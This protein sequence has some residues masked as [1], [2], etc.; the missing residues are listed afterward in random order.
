MHGAD[1]YRVCNKFG[2]KDLVNLVCFGDV[3]VNGVDKLG[4]IVNEKTWRK[5]ADEKIKFVGRRIWMNNCLNS[6][7]LHVCI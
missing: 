3:S 5:F 7:R 2:L 1:R 6:D 4:M